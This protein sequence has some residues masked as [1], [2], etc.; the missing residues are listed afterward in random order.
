MESEGHPRGAK[1]RIAGAAARSE[2][3][4]VTCTNCGWDLRS[5]KAAAAPVEYVEVQVAH[6]RWLETL[7]DSEQDP[8]DYFW[9]LSHA[10]ELFSKEIGTIP[11]IYLPVRHRTE[12]LRRAG[13]LLAEDRWTYIQ[14]VVINRRK[15]LALV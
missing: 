11:F 7:G 2:P 13:W 10:V 1:R 3:P 6:E 15:P 5:G 9:L 12:V 8:S 14:S 4:F